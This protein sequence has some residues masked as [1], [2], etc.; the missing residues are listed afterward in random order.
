MSTLSREQAEFHAH[1]II[2]G[3]I[4]SIKDHVALLLAQDAAH[5][6]LLRQREEELVKRMT[7]WN[8]L[9]DGYDESIAQLQNQLAVMNGPG[10]PYTRWQGMLEALERRFPDPQPYASS[11][12]AEAHYLEAIDRVLAQLADST[13]RCAQLEEEL[14]VL[15]KCECMDANGSPFEY[16]MECNGT[17][18]KRTFFTERPPA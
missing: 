10:T 17:G 2:Y 14:K 15:A 16:C 9:I 13:A 4:Y 18:D 1:Q 5:R 12:P 3:D 8:T 6:D 11:D 7:A